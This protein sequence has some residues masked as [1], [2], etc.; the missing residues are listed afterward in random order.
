MLPRGGMEIV[1]EAS[2]AP[3]YMPFSS[4]LNLFRRRSLAVADAPCSVTPRFWKLSA[5]AARLSACLHLDVATMT[6]AWH[7]H[8]TMPETL[9][10]IWRTPIKRK[11]WGGNCGSVRAPGSLVVATCSLRCA[12][13]APRHALPSASPFA[14][15]FAPSMPLG[16]AAGSQ[17]RSFFCTAHGRESGRSTQKLALYASVQRQPELQ[18]QSRANSCTSEIDFFLG[19]D[20][21]DQETTP[22]ELEI[23]YSKRLIGRQFAGHS[24][25][26]LLLMRRGLHAALGALDAHSSVAAVC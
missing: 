16:I 1:F 4:W 7:G 23:D 22:R 14:A 17:R 15:G 20:E 10:L 5:A 25:A 11:R 6:G 12:S 19:L 9:R 8:G 26:A 21:D 24:G 3:S 18:W 13:Y 2:R